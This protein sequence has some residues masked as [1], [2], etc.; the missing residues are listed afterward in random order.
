MLLADRK[1]R[2][3]AQRTVITLYPPN[4]AAAIASASKLKL[5]ELQT[6]KQE[7]EQALTRQDAEL[8]RQAAELLT[9]DAMLRALDEQLR[10][11][12]AEMR[13]LASSVA[14][15]QSHAASEEVAEVKEAYNLDACELGGTVWEAPLLL[16][17]RPFSKATSAFI[18]LLVLFNALFQGQALLALDCT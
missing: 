2:A 13:R 8:K 1:G 6:A 15:L 10:Q 11:Q 18:G 4:G 3:R 9:K 17:C 5:I 7:Q 16:G 14:A 12:A